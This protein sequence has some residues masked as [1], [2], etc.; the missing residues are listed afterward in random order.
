MDAE[1]YTSWRFAERSGPW[2]K[3]D[4][5]YQAGLRGD[6]GQVSDLA[7]MSNGARYRYRARKQAAD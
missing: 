1:S 4:I 5:S 7:V 6:D 3:W 2:N